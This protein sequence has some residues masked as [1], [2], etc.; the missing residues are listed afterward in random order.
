[1]AHLG[2]RSRGGTGAP[3][4]S[5]ERREE[6]VQRLT[7]L[8]ISLSHRSHPVPTAVHQ[9]QAGI[10]EFKAI[11]VSCSERFLT[12]APVCVVKVKKK[13]PDIL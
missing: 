2:G 6:R 11:L 8:S 12:W 5:E 4:G 10:L 7:C 1:M 9:H 13:A 3:R